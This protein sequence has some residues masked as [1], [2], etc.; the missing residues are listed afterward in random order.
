MRDDF[1]RFIEEFSAIGSHRS[2]MALRPGIRHAHTLAMTCIYASSSW[3]PA[4]SGLYAESIGTHL[5]P[6]I[7]KYVEYLNK[8]NLPNDGDLQGILR[9]VIQ[10]MSFQRELEEKINLD[11]LSALLKVFR[12]ERHL[13]SQSL[14]LFG[15]IF[16]RFFSHNSVS[17]QYFLKRKALAYVKDVLVSKS[18]P[19]FLLAGLAFLLLLESVVDFLNQ[20]I[21]CDVFLPLARC[22][23]LTNYYNKQMY[24]ILVIFIKAIEHNQ[25]EHLMPRRTLS[26]LAQSLNHPSAICVTRLTPPLNPHIKLSQDLSFCLFSMRRNLQILMYPWR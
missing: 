12:Y 24:T 20:L 23:A 10:L 5:I 1:H 16:M 2:L 21:S 17:R 15:V 8:G 3:T 26:Y 13:T 11:I 22:L 9:L 25:G 18:R 6:C 19:P 4:D 14:E 7:S